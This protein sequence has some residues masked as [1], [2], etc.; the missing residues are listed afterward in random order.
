MNQPETETGFD[1]SAA[2]LTTAQWRN[3]PARYSLQPEQLR[4]TTEPETD[5]WQRSFYGFRVDNAPALLWE[6]SE[7][8]TLSVRAT[9]NYRQ[10]FDQC[11]LLVYL[12]ADHWL[13]VS[14]EYEDATHS[15]LGSVVTNRGYSD[16]ASSDIP[17]TNEH[18]YRLSRRGPD[19]L[20][21]HSDDGRAFQQMRVCHLER[22]GE[23]TAEM[24]RL[25]P[26]QLAAAP[27]RLGVYACSPQPSSFEACFDHCSLAPSQ[28]QAHGGN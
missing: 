2:D 8:L 7:N 6:R 28:W 5:L 10:R 4:L 3:E 19:F 27:I 24:G 23:T 1:S 15:H 17:T 20:I 21:E 12:D 9:F 14:I 16:W 25:P 22:L 26:A 18:W 11:G 13:K